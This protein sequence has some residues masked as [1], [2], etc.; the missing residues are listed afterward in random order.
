MSVSRSWFPA[1]CLGL[2]LPACAATSPAPKA[3]RHT[4]EEVQRLALGAWTRVEGEHF[5]LDGELLAAEPE[6][7]YLERDH[8]VDIVHPTCVKKLTIAAF[9]GQ[10]KEVDVLGGLGALSTPSHGFLLVFSL[11]IWILSSVSSHYA[12]SGV[13][14]LEYGRTR[15]APLDTPSVRRWARFPQGMPRGYLTTPA[16]WRITDEHCVL[17]PPPADHAGAPPTEGSTP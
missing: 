10:G 12:Q 17:V 3:Y 5:T 9:E 8:R 14:H 16:G 4:I 2:L 13:G 6:S 7:L 1:L 15:V 11:P